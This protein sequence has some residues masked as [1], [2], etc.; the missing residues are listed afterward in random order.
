[1]HFKRSLSKQIY[2]SVSLP[3][4]V[5]RGGIGQHKRGWSTGGIG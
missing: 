2:C 1:M 4:V 3:W 5:K